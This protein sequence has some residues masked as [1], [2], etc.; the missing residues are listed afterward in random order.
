MSKWIPLLFSPRTTALINANE[1]QESAQNKLNNIT[2][3]ICTSHHRSVRVFILAADFHVE[4]AV[5]RRGVGGDETEVQFQ[6]ER[7]RSTG[8]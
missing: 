2:R 6:R 7:K 3:P 8:V 4:D 1:I 5:L